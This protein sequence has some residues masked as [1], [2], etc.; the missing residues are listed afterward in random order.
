MTFAEKLVQ[1]KYWIE[2][3]GGVK[4]DEFQG[5]NTFIYNKLNRREKLRK[6]FYSNSQTS[7]KCLS[8]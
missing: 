1:A 8:E 3:P 5:Q 6:A 7:R 4:C 2:A